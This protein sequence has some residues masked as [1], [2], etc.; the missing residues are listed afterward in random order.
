MQEKRKGK[1]TIQIQNKEDLRKNELIAIGRRKWADH[2]RYLCNHSQRYPDYTLVGSQHPAQLRKAND[3]YLLVKK[4]PH[5]S[6]A[7]VRVSQKP[8]QH[9]Q[10]EHYVD[11]ENA[12]SIDEDPAST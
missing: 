6:R 8:N 10:K 1:R 12:Y 11:H 5:P 9:G 4:F 3:R 2:K 7:P